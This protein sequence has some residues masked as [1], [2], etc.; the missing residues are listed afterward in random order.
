MC[1][2]GTQKTSVNLGFSNRF[3]YQKELFLLCKILNC[4]SESKWSHQVWAGWAYCTCIRS[5]LTR[6]VIKL[7]G[8]RGVLHSL[9]GS[10]PQTFYSLQ[11]IWR[12]GS[13]W[14]CL[15][16]SFRGQQNREGWEH[17]LEVS[18]IVE[19]RELRQVSWPTPQMVG[20][21]WWGGKSS[22]C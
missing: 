22:V 8:R 6:Q 16:H 12:L 2:L 21:C 3:H 14:C 17:F 19:G 5:S 20:E 9:L 4:L 11:W 15:L 10:L 18:L 7:P 1:I 13:P